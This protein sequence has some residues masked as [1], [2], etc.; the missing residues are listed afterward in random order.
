MVR[1]IP[2]IS[3]GC[4]CAIGPVSI[5]WGDVISAGSSYSL[6]PRMVCD[7]F[8]VDCEFRRNLCSNSGNGSP[9]MICL[10]GFMYLVYTGWLKFV[11][12][13]IFCDRSVPFGLFASVFVEK[14]TINRLFSGKTFLE[15]AK[16]DIK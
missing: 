13:Y 4:S 15:Y 7:S 10:V 3:V 5:K 6:R 8:S 1:S 9:F 14:Q 2:L 16:K 12:D 11:F